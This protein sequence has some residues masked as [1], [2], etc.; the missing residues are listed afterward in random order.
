MSDDTPKP[1]RL[2]QIASDTA[3]SALSFDTTFPKRYKLF[4]QQ[5]INAAAPAQ[6]IPSPESGAN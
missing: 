6:P 5:R 1:H 3:N 4:D 2:A